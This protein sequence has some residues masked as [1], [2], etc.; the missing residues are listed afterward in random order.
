L[1]LVIIDLAFGSSLT[2]VGSALIRS[3]LTSKTSLSQVASDQR[4][5]TAWTTLQLDASAIPPAHLPALAGVTRQ[6]FVL[7]RVGP[8]NQLR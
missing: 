2:L 4:S 8:I 6:S 3:D 1:D 7:G 5:V